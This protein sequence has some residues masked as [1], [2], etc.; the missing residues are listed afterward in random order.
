IDTTAMT[1]ESVP[2]SVKPGDGV[3]S[4]TVNK[5]GVLTIKVTKIFS[6]SSI[7]K[8]LHLVEEAGNK[9][10]QT[11]KFITRFAAYYTPAVVGIASMIAFLPPLFLHESFSLWLYRALVMLVISCPCALVISIPL[12][13][14]G[15]V[16][17]ASRKGILVK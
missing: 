5:D 12:G 1:G 6:E 10:T 17:W 8:I 13:Y 3:L 2:R 4:G 16:G 15:G 11:E 7:S 9:K 14:F